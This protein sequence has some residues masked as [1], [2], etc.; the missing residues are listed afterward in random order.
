MVGVKTDVTA[1]EITWQSLIQSN[2]VMHATHFTDNNLFK[3][4]NSPMRASLVAQW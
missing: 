3:P 1:L 4:F 2:I